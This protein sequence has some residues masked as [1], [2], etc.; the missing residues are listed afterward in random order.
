[1]VAVPFLVAPQIAASSL[2]KV[3][4]QHA[5]REESHSDSIDTIDAYAIKH[6]AQHHTLASDWTKNI[7][8]QVNHK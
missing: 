1:M 5:R 6:S 3:Q 2:Y 4:L 8:S 7:N